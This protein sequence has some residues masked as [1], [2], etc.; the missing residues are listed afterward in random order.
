M[1]KSL[2]SISI[3]ITDKLKTIEN[4][5]NKAIA[6]EIN[7]RLSQSQISIVKDVKKLIPQW[8]SSQPE[9]GALLSE[10]PESL[11]GQFGIYSSTQ[12]IVNRIIFS[13]VE[14]T[15]V[16]FIRYSNNLRGGF[17]LN[18]QPKDF[19]NLLSLPEGHTVYNG[20]DLHWLDWLLLR[21]DS[22]IVTNYEYNPQ[23]GIGRSR[24]GN[25]VAGGSFRVPP[26][27]SGTRDDN[28]I[29]RAFV[30]PSQE[31]A[32]TKIFVKYLQ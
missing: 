25:M 1:E 12:S 8:L 11:K 31:D 17:E 19:I 14:S 5:I 4:N 3:Q 18:F 32:I 2:M 26:Q 28:F 9:I 10:T 13:V 15:S 20:G 6:E 21:G 30:G 22:I 27:Y 29:T 16:K 24:L 23:T 7:K